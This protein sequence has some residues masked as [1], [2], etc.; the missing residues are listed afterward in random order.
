LEIPKKSKRNNNKIDN[1]PGFVINSVINK[2]RKG[3]LSF[4]QFDHK[5]LNK[6]PKELI[7]QK[8]YSFEIGCNEKR[9]PR[10]SINLTP[11]KEKSLNNMNTLPNVPRTFKK[12]IRLNKRF[13][14]A[15]DLK[16]GGGSIKDNKRIVTH[17][18]DISIIRKMKSLD[19]KANKKDDDIYDRRYML[20]P[21][22]LQEENN[23]L[24]V[25]G[26]NDIFR[27]DDIDANYEG[28]KRKLIELRKYR[29]ALIL[30]CCCRIAI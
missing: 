15:E 25:E 30:G 27:M 17:E 1:N 3:S 20:L 19:I 23:Q 21:S 12:A 28:I 10:Q 24:I 22:N 26:F 18:Q 9:E 7:L 13:K 29:E 8:N 16:Q 14:L 2:K 5:I 6:K 4:S 11:Q